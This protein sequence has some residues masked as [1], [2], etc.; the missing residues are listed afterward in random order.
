[1]PIHRSDDQSD[2][3]ALSEPESSGTPQ[4]TSPR[5][6]YAADTRQGPDC[7]ALP[8]PE[9]LASD[10][11]ATRSNDDNL[12]SNSRAETDEAFGI[13]RSGRVQDGSDYPASRDARQDDGLNRRRPWQQNDGIR[14]L[15]AGH[16]DQRHEIDDSSTSALLSRKDALYN[17]Q[18]WPGPTASRKANLLFPYDPEIIPKYGPL[19]IRAL[20]FT[21]SWFSINM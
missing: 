3:P 12:P 17:A 11:T 5:P 6:T 18:H 8:E 2:C 13:S 7:P 21:P 15:E 4:H 16:P 10:I 14:D 1:M 19:G 20:L 9:S